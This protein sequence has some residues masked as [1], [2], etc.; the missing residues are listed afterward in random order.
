MFCITAHNHYHN[1]H[2]QAVEQK[3]YVEVMVQGKPR[4]LYANRFPYWKDVH[5]FTGPVFKALATLFQESGDGHTK[6]KH[7]E[8]DGSKLQEFETSVS[9]E[10]LQE[11]KRQRDEAIDTLTGALHDE[12]NMRIFGR[13]L[14]DSLR[15]EHNFHND[16]P[17]Q[18]VETFMFGDPQTGEGCL[19]L[20]EVFGLAKGWIMANGKVFGPAGKIAAGAVQR[21]LRVLQDD[22]PSTPTP[23]NGSNSE[24]VSP[25]QSD[26]VIPTIS[27]N[28]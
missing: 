15:E 28:D 7:I 19:D 10:V 26:E 9:V 20:E 8:Q 27:L 6:Q 16:R 3:P 24:N 23:A 1:N 13:L 12:R 25:S 4:R 18:E 11:Q 17:I 21:K 22:S 2:M 5:N 14:M